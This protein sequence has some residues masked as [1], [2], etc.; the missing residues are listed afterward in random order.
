MHRVLPRQKRSIAWSRGDVNHRRASGPKHELSGCRGGCRLTPVEAL[1]RRAR[2]ATRGKAPWAS[3]ARAAM[4]VAGPHVQRTGASAHS[5]GAPSGVGR[6]G[7][8]G[9]GAVARRPQTVN[10]CAPHGC[11]QPR[12]SARRHASRGRDVHG[13]DAPGGP[14]AAPAARPIPPG[15]TR[16]TQQTGR[17]PCTPYSGRPPLCP[18]A[19]TAF[20]RAAA[21]IGRRYASLG[22]GRFTHGHPQ[23]GYGI[24]AG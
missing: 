1:G 17:R 4:T 19:S 16:T 14:T 22:H 24:I 9:G 8:A 3:L 12:A 23:A 11:S 5:D 20:Q 18:T 7:H 10:T 2:I 21:S 13:T 15:A 6:R